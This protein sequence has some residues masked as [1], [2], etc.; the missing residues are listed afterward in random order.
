MEGLFLIG[1]FFIPE[2][3]VYYCRKAQHDK[4]KKS[5]TYLHKNIKDYDVDMECTTARV[6]WLM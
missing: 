2:S 3:P 1:L 4:A 5:L 6:T